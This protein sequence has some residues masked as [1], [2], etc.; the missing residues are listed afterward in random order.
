MGGMDSEVTDSTRSLLLESA[1]FAP[2][3]I[4][5]TA[6]RL[7]LHSEASHRFER[8]VDPAG[9]LAAANRA[10]YLLGEIAGGKP[11]AG[12]ADSYPGKTKPPVII[13]R[14]ERI[15]RLLGLAIDGRQAE[16]LL[17]SIGMNTARQRKSRSLK[18]TPPTSRPDISREA[19]LIE[20]L[21]RLH[22]YDR[23]P[24]TL[25]LLRSSGGKNDRRLGWERRLGAFMSGEGLAEAINLPFTTAAL[26]R[27]FAGLWHAPK[28]VAVLNPLAQENGELRHSL[29]PGLIEN[30]KLN[31]AHRAE[32]FAAYHL[33]KTFQLS[34]A[35][36]PTERQS[37][38]A[39]LHG[40]R[41][42][43]G[44][45]QGAAPLLSFLDCKGLV[46]ALLELFHLTHLTGWSALQLDI[47][48]PGQS[49][50]FLLN[51]EAAGY[52]GRLHPDICERLEVPQCCV[53][54]LDFEKLLEYA[55][56]QIAAHGLPRYPAVERDVAI[57]VDRDFAAQQII[58]WFKNSG[59]ALIE[60]VEVFDQYLGAPIPEGKK[61]LA[62]KVSYR[63]EDRTLTDTEIN[64]LHQSL[65]DR[66]GTTF[67]AERRS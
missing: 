13:L 59:N 52:L 46:E 28:P 45:R 63:A 58:D 17:R 31:L 54:E 36:E 37:V 25:P 35:G 22:G 56:R 4:R 26:N 14:E 67:G 42:R 55:P 19:D 33:G 43:R 40:P 62:Y 66:L 3:T 21:A 39:L 34:P 18:V 44:L 64:A 16:K 11:M 51:A 48:H 12:V 32:S 10:V 38:A 6:K 49:A 30:L 61:S 50:A 20:E 47:L 29:L 5:R 8:G 2:T 65:V 53:F 15:E 9:T 60:Y 1:N 7:A 23:I 24:S 27:S 41:P 57:V